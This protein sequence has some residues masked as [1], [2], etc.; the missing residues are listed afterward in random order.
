[1]IIGIDVDNV[2]VNTTQCVLDFVNERLPNVN[3]KIDDIHEYWM[4][5]V[6]PEGYKWIIPCAFS[7]KQ[8][9]KN[10]KLI[11]GRRSIFDS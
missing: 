11:D 8:M 2:I 5:E 9:W 6:I 1:M 3:L 10:V 4:E 7:S